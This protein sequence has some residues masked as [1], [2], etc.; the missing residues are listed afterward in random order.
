MRAW[1][2]PLA[3]AGLVELAAHFLSLSWGFTLIVVLF[4]V[5]GIRQQ[6][7]TAQTADLA[8]RHAALVVSVGAVKDTAD[9]A[10]PKSGGTVTGGLTVNGDHHIGGSLY[11]SGGTLTVADAVTNNGSVTVYANH[12]VHGNG[13]YTGDLGTG[14][15]SVAGNSFMPNGSLGSA[16]APPTGGSAGSTIAGSQ[17][18]GAFF[19]GSGAANWAQG[20]ANKV[21]AI[22]SNLQANGITN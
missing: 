7:N 1:G 9:N 21:D 11:G 17:Y 16:S 8:A 6:A 13:T 14:G 22:I 2:G 10:L 3:A 15:L 12:G 4:V 18:C 5:T 20:I 19:T